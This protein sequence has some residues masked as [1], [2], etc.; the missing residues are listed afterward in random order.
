MT[1]HF[2]NSDSLPGS[3][4]GRL[5]SSW[6]ISYLWF[7]LVVAGSAQDSPVASETSTA[8][9][10]RARSGVVEMKAAMWGEDYQ[11][12]VHGGEGFSRTMFKSF[13][14]EL[15]KDFRW[16]IYK[17]RPNEKSTSRNFWAIPIR[18]DLVGSIDDVY[19]GRD[20]LT[21]L[22]VLPDDRFHLKV[23][24]RLHDSFEEGSFRLEMIRALVIEQM[25]MPVATT[26][27]A[28]AVD[29]VEPP[30]WIVHGFDQ[31]LEHR[32]LGSPSG[33]YEGALRSGQILSPD[34]IFSL[35]DPD[36]LD[37]LSRAVF[38][39]S[40]AAMVETLLDQPQGDIGLREVLG[41]LGTRQGA[42]VTALMRQHFPAFR[43]MEQ[44]MEKWWTLQVAALGQQQGFEFM[45]R[46]ETERWLTEA[47]TVRF[48]PQ[49]RPPLPEKPKK[50]LFQRLKS[51][52]QEKKET[53][54]P[55]TGTIEQWKEFIGR[56]DAETELARCFSRI[57]QLKQ[58]GFPLYRPV[59]DGY[60]GVIERLIQ[61][62]TKDI[63]ARILA[64]ADM[65]AAIFDTLVRSED[66]MNYYEATRAPQRSQAF[67]DYLKLREELERKPPPKRKDRIS[68]YLDALEKEFR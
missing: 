1:G 40:A 18:V 34:E 11:I 4:R 49:L 47:L 41:D 54:A 48:D 59:F 16:A 21:R 15:R 6:G 12:S 51:K 37:P 29:V 39:A 27:S 57:Q 43:E 30:A 23:S 25:L 19:R 7:F 22:Q 61:K 45:D 38:R 8:G 17:Y 53:E 24:V 67:D 62:R 56:K 33:F 5:V 60:E 68:Q 52:A 28:L 31:L 3:G 10:S 2:V 65:R 32:D 26:P 36:S 66:Y 63:D 14:N 64:L 46:D 50:G 58:T 9:E 55:F 44:G 20:T 42:T 13:A 35:E